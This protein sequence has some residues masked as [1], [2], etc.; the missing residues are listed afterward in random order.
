MELSGI[1]GA[2]LRR[3]EVVESTNSLLKAEA[4]AGLVEEGAVVVAEHQTAG[5]GR[6]DRRW[7]APPGKALLFSA[8]L[9][10]EL[11]P[12]KLP[13][14][15]LMVGLAVSESVS[16]FVGESVSEN[17]EL[18]ITNYELKESD[19]SPL[20]SKIQ[21]PKSKIILKWPNDILAGGR[22]LGGIL[23]ESGF[24][25][26]GRRFVVAGVGLNV[27]QT[28][29]DFPPGL[30]NAAA[31]LYLVTGQIK[32]REAV[33]GMLLTALER[34]LLRLRDEGCGWIVPEWLAQAPIVNQRVTV[35]EGKTKITGLGLGLEPNGA[36]KLRL[37][38]GSVRLIH[39]GDLDR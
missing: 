6:L 28:A 14:A 17:Y 7:E 12:D 30:R 25:P 23:C 4:E 29:E 18:R 8:L 33:L 35:T 22:K 9:Y 31:S 11:P 15:G 20:Q 3:L 32:E 19:K 5:R 13:L 2:P 16:R 34:S 37:D 39:T 21:N 27:N 26:N 1:S 36:L 10:P 24:G 38:D